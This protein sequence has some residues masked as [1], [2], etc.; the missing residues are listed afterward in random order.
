MSAFKNISLYIPHVFPNFNKE[1]INNAFS[2]IGDVDHIDLVGKEDRNGKHYNAVYIHFNNWRNTESFNRLRDEIADTGSA[3]L[4]YDKTWYWIV[5]PNNAKK[6]V[7]GDRKPRIDLGDSDVINVTKVNTPDN[8]IVN[9]PTPIENDYVYDP[10]DAEIDAEIEKMEAQLDEVEAEM[11]AEDEHLVFV[12]KRYLQQIEEENSQLRN[13]L[14]QL[15]TALINADMMY[16]A[17][18]AKVR[19]FS[20]ANQVISIIEEQL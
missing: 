16:R 8:P 19:A 6:H 18:A 14:F 11:D 5:L 3:R 13:E 9:L 1:Y 17:E 20:N 10:I 2:C 15:R 7:S 12:D 4:Y